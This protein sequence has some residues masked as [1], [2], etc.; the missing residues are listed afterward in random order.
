ME[1]AYDLDFLGKELKEK[2]LVE[3]EDGAKAIVL[4]VYDFLIKSADLSPSPVDNYFKPLYEM[5]KQ[6]LLEV[7]DKIDGEE[8]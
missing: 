7:A 8:G 6:R 1:K 3:V 4:A 5:G 2:G